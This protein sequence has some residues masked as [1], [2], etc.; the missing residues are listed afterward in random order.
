MM[1]YRQLDFSDH[2]DPLK[3]LRTIEKIE[4]NPGFNYFKTVP[5]RLE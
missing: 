4:M 2:D 5:L 1:E 3:Q